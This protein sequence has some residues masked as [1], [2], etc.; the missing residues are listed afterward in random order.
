M[1]LGQLAVYCREQRVLVDLSAAGV[2]VPAGRGAY[3]T[4]AG[5]GLP[6][7]QQVPQQLTGALLSAAQEQQRRPQHL[8]W[9][10]SSVAHHVNAVRQRQL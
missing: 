3:R 1:A 6:P 5:V 4:A 7:R 9:C 8:V 2:A 10:A